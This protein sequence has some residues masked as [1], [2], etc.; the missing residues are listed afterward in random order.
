MH[1]GPPNSWPSAIST[2]GLPP[3]PSIGLSAKL[4]SK[5]WPHAPVHR[6][7]EN[8]VYIVTSGTLYKRHLFD[9]DAK[10]DLLERM[11]LSMSKQ[12]GWQLEAWAVM[13]NQ[14]PD[15]LGAN[16]FEA[17]FRPRLCIWRWAVRNLSNE[18]SWSAER[19]VC[20]RLR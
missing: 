11:L 19:T 4:P 5:D 16:I 20:A 15:G 12:H 7:S 2:L 18:V 6:M 13:A 8:A 14:L 17:I 10:R 9:V 3:G 1:T